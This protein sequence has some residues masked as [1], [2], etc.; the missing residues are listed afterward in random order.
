MKWLRTPGNPEDTGD[1][2][3]FALGPLA[4]YR[5][6][7]R[8]S[9]QR[10]RFL[11]NNNPLMSKRDLIFTHSLIDSVAY[12]TVR[13][14]NMINSGSVSEDEVFRWEMLLNMNALLLR[15]TQPEV[16]VIFLAGN[17]GDYF[18]QNLETAI[19]SI[20]NDWGIPHTELTSLN[21]A[22]TL[23]ASYWNTTEEDGTDAPPTL[24]SDEVAED[25]N[26]N[27]NF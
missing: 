11:S 17:D 23:I 9:T 3:G 6:E 20:L 15:D 5:Q 10:V 13:L 18:N 24:S 19:R 27:D 7:L 25:P 26:Y 14:F 21:E 4:D 8:I 16:P 22:A 1:H 2:D 12:P